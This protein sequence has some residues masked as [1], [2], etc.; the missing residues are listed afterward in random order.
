MSTHPRAS[1]T[2]RQPLQLPL[3][4]IL[5]L[6]CSCFRL[7]LQGK[8]TDRIVAAGDYPSTEFSHGIC[9]TCLKRLYP[10]VA[11]RLARTRRQAKAVTPGNPAR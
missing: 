6:C 7:Q 4:G 9:P 3:F 1:A 2:V 10:E 5:V 11:R 8:W